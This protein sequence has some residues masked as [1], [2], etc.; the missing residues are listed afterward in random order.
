MWMTSCPFCVA[1]LHKRRSAKVIE[2][3]VPENFRKSLKATL[4]L[5]RGKIIKFGSQ[6]KRSA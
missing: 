2:F 1:F 6:I 4:A 5:H 3:Y